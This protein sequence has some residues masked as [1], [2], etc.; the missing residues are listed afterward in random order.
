MHIDIKDITAKN[1][2]E[3]V[4]LI[5]HFRSELLSLNKICTDEDLPAARKEAEEYLEKD[6]RYIR[7]M[8]MGKPSD[9]LIE[10][11]RG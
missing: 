4:S 5:A 3:I 7:S 2:E 8:L 10:I 1:Y 11:R 6:I 9:I